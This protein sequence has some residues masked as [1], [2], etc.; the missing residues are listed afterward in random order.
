MVAESNFVFIVSR[1]EQWVRKVKEIC[2]AIGF[3]VRIFQTYAEYLASVKRSGVQ[4]CVIIDSRIDGQDCAR[5]HQ[6]MLEENVALPVIVATT[7]SNLQLIAQEAGRLSFG[8]V[9]KCASPLQL[10]TSIDAALGQK[11]KVATHIAIHH[12][13]FKLKKLTPRQRIIVDQATVG[14]INVKIANDLKMSVKQIE[15]DRQTAYKKLEVTSAAEMATVVTLA[16][17]HDII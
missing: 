16:S 2:L 8:C 11:K 12:S 4:G 15:R 5:M 3:S 13:H 10:R 9:A 7:V 6:R 14:H 1:D 17:M